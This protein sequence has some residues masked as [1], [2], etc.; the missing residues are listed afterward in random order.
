[1]KTPSRRY[2]T[3][4]CLLSL[5][6]LASPVYAGLQQVVSVP[7]IGANDT[8]VWS[9]LGGDLTSLTPPVN[10]A[11]LNGLP[12]TVQGPS[13]F[14]I[15]QGST[16]NADFLPSDFVISAFDINS[17]NPLFTPI[18]IDLPLRALA[19][20]MQVQVNAFGPFSA[21]LQA[22]DAASN[23]LGSVTVNSSIGGNGDGSAVFLGGMTTSNPIASVLI[24]SPTAGLA[25]DTVFLQDAPEPGCLL[26]AA[27]ALALLIIRKRA[28][29]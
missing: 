11:T 9:A 27:P 3:L 7:G 21:T 25:L 23:L 10:S 28:R 5:A 18:E 26:L 12:Y 15:F 2:S 13:S 22:F 16:Y 29:R 1:M 24:S 8:I 14:T 17:F 6:F 20:G 19:I 4:I